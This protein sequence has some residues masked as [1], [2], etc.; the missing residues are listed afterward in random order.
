MEEAQDIIDELKHM[1]SE[2]KPHE[3]SDRK[4]RLKQLS[5]MDDAETDDT[6]QK[7]AFL[8]GGGLCKNQQAELLWRNHFHE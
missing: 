7:A 5:S 6:P 1:H 2:A 3:I 4:A 8:S